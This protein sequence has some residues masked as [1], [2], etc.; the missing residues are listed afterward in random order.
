MCSNEGAVV[1][2]RSDQRWDCGCVGVMRGR[3]CGGG[4]NLRILFYERCDEGSSSFSPAERAERVRS[5]CLD[6]NVFVL[7]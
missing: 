1:Q 7:P 3:Y 6:K 4:A 2:Q 5:R